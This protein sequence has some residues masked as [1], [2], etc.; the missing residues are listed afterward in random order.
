[1]PIP[2]ARIKS[3]FCYRGPNGQVWKVLKIE[4]NGLWYMALDEAS[5]SN[6]WTIHPSIKQPMKIS[7]FGNAVSCR[8]FPCPSDAGKTAKIFR[9]VL[10]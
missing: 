4:G 6:N 1:M 2:T 9:R 8:Y 3:G 5:N 10:S 7:T